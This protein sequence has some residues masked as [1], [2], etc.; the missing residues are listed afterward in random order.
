MQNQTEQI[1]N[2][3]VKSLEIPDNAK[4]KAEKRYE[5]IGNWLSREKSTLAQFNPEF[6]SQGSIRLNTTIKPLKDDEEYDLDAVCLLNNLNVDICTQ[7]N[8]KELIGYELDLYVKANNF[9][10]P[11]DE[12]KR[13]WTL[14]YSDSAQFHM[15]VCYLQFLMKKVL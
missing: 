8:V 15:D 2:N 13:C 9:N 6:Y 10:K 11:L 5:S 7:K 3:L 1:L 4:E 12:G 14:K